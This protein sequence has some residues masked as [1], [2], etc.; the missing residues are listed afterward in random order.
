MNIYSIIG[1]VM[2]MSVLGAGFVLST[3]NLHIFV[4]E[5]GFLLVAGGT[6]AA[7]SISFQLNRIFALFKVFLTRVLGG[8]RIHFSDV[9]KEL[10][11]AAEAYRKGESLE[12]LMKKTKDHFFQDCLGL[13][14]EG[15]LQGEALDDAMVERA[16]S[17]YHHQTEEASRVKTMAKYPPAFGLMGTSLG[18][19]V[20]LSNLGG[21]DALQKVGPAMGLCLTA[22]LYGIVIA[23]LVLFP[24]SEHLIDA[25]KEMYF[26]NKLI[27]EGIR[28]IQQKENPLIVAEKLNSYLSPKDRLDWKK[29]LGKA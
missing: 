12:E 29:V 15:I 27:I 4:D 7:V 28:L 1:F 21:K 20:L 13:M 2:A 11:Q 14:K 24:I 25:T 9:V 17:M 19:I 10:M 16:K 23:N 18:M 3:N 8:G 22:T 6:L 26:K 5:V